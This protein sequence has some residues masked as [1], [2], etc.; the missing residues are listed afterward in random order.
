MKVRCLQS[1][2]VDG[3]FRKGPELNDNAEV[4]SPGEVFDVADTFV[5]NRNV[6][7]V[8]V[9]PAGGKAAIK[10]AKLPEDEDEPAPPAGA[11]VPGG[12][13]K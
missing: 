3:S 7:E 9:P 1:C 10:W 6:L 8:V 4:I 13:K 11:V 12:G 5:V 2:Y